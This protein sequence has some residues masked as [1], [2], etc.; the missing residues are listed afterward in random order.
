MIVFKIFTIIAL[1]ICGVALALSVLP[2]GIMAFSSGSPIL[3]LVLIS[4][5]RFSINDVKIFGLPDTA[6]VAFVQASMLVLCAFV[7]YPTSTVALVY[8]SMVVF[9]FVGERL[10][11]D[12]PEVVVNF[13]QETH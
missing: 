8:L 2:V 10:T 7:L 4:Y 13:N 5:F 11:A 1:S 3:G 9:I 12:C 6:A